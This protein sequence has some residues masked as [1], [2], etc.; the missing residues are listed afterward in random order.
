MYNINRFIIFVPEI[1][2]KSHPMRTIFFALF[3]IIVFAANA[4]STYPN[5]LEEILSLIDDEIEIK[6]QYVDRRLQK[7]D[8]LKIRLNSNEILR[9]YEEIGNEYRTINIDSALSYYSAGLL[10]AE[11]LGD[12]V[13]TQRLTLSKASILPVIGAIKEGVE[14]FDSINPENVFPENKRLYYESGNRLFFYISSFYSIPELQRTYMRRGAILTDSLLQEL[15][16]NSPEHNLYEAQ[17][18]YIH[19]EKAIASALLDEAISTLPLSDNVFA[20]A[21]SMRAS[22][23][24]ALGDT[25]SALYYLA[26]S[27]LSDIVCGTLEG[28]S[29]QRL[30]T[31]L[32]EKGDIERAY[33]FLLTSLDNAVTSGAKLRAME[34]SQALPIIEKAFK[35]QDD[36]K[37]KWLLG[38]VASLTIALSVIVGVILYLRREKNKLEILKMRLSKANHVKE[39]YISQFLNLCSIYMDKQEEFNKIAIRKIT[40]GQI[41]DLY[42]TIKSGKMIDEQNASFYEIF[43]NAFIHIYPTFIDDV[44]ALLMPDKRIILTNNNT[45]NTELRI[46]AFMRLGVDDSARISRFL[47]LS[48]NTVYTYRNKMKS[49]AKQRDTFDNDVMSIGHIS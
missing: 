49:R 19:G 40:T 5:T 14:I 16:T 44:N 18:C 3:S 37:L 29:L 23:S 24:I 26:L 43:D 22:L 42:Q 28:S 17:L 1:H 34:S 30:G 46:L 15:A 27:A 45:L 39:T 4:S 21:A 36:L 2:P 20:R 12:S 32:Y 10:R 35:Q 31:A 7:I 41:D 38:L 25:D 8:S 48:L 47:G 33:K 11:N 9:V 13:A 6:E